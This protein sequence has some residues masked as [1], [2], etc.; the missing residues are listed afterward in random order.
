MA[1]LFFA[2]PLPLP[3][4]LYAG[5]LAPCARAVPVVVLLA[6]SVSWSVPGWAQEAPD[7]AAFDAARAVLAE[8]GVLVLYDAPRVED[9]ATVLPNLRFFTPVDAAQA[10]QITLPLARLEAGA[11]ALSVSPLGPFEARLGPSTGGVVFDITA[12][13]ARFA[14][15]GGPEW[16][17]MELGVPT[18]EAR[19]RGGS[20][21][22]G[23]LATAN[24][25][26]YAV[27]EREDGVWVD[28]TLAWS[29]VGLRWAT[30]APA[31]DLTLDV[32][33]GPLRADLATRAGGFWETV[34]WM[35]AIE[36]G[37]EGVWE[38]EST[39]VRVEATT[40]TP[41]GPATDLLSWD[42]V[43]SDAG[44][45]S[46]GVEGDL[47]AQGLRYASTLPGGAVE[48]WNL[49]DLRVEGVIPTHR[50]E[51]S[52]GWELSVEA[53]GT[54]D[55]ADAPVPFAFAWEGEG[56][57][58]MPRSWMVRG[59]DGGS[60][61]RPWAAT[62]DRLTADAWQGRLE[63][64]DG[65]VEASGTFEGA[66][67]PVEEAG[68]GVASSVAEVAEP[69]WSG[70]IEASAEGL[71]AW[72][73]AVAAASPPVPVVGALAALGGVLAQGGV[74][75]TGGVRAVLGADGVRVEPMEGPAASPTEQDGVGA[76]PQ[77]DLEEGTAP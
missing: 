30:P 63:A 21:V 3:R 12:E 24:G 16:R 19:L 20:D 37:M 76:V 29:D 60:N 23:M 65:W 62:L 15:E 25:L 44:H 57:L 18:M 31:G 33:A 75:G 35:V 9:G 55:R 42:R 10:W 5:R 40:A 4:R 69:V 50:A 14:L 71:E 56:D 38:I 47:R 41:N 28:R 32:Q 54:R 58:V 26:S 52:Q 7:V 70:A 43:E 48:P 53:R 77:G 22:F 13:G 36:K 11:G 72:G 45:T 17:V 66:V 2:R 8:Q 74:S 1:P 61:W 39:N 59:V 46:S 67:E 6:A 34:P 27:R 51:A 73:Q 68:E 64:G 49:F